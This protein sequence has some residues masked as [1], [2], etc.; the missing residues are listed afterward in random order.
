MRNNYTWNHYKMD[1]ARKAN[2]DRQRQAASGPYRPS[3]QTDTNYTR[4]SEFR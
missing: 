1:E 2:S 4:G 3:Y